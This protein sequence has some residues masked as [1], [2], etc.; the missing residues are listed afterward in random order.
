MVRQNRNS[1]YPEAIKS[2]LFRLLLV[3]ETMTEFTL[4]EMQHMMA[5]MNCWWGENCEICASVRK[6]LQ[7][8]IAKE[9]EKPIKETRE[10]AGHQVT[11]ERSTS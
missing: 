3:A 1:N 9:Q 4:E 11:I 7:E 10:I 2:I 6:K 5:R 8:M